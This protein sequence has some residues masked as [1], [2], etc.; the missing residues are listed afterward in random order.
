[1]I[2]FWGCGGTI[3]LLWMGG[4]DFSQGSTIAFWDRRASAFWDGEGDRARPKPKK[5][6][7]FEPFFLDTDILAKTR[8]L[9]RDR[10]LFLYSQAS[11]I[12][13]HSCPPLLKGG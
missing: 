2:S 10:L 6:G 7:F 3:A 13:L 9:N 1:M 12:A 4:R 5:P 8:F 11:V